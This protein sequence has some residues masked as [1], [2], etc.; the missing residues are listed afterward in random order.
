MKILE[1]THCY[2]PKRVMDV[3]KGMA[4]RFIESFH[5]GHNV[6]A[7]F[8]VCS[9][10][11]GYRPEHDRWGE[12]VPVANLCTGLISYVAGNRVV[13]VYAAEVTLKHKHR[14]CCG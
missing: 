14:G 5:R 8:M 6:D 11:D 9:A 13:V 12:K 4:V 3:G 2:T 10:P 1:Q 7:K